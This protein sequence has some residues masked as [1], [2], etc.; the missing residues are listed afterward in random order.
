[1]RRLPLIGLPFLALTA[2]CSQSGDTTAD[3]DTAMPAAE[4]ST[5]SDPAMSD[6]TSTTPTNDSATGS[7]ATPQDPN[8]TGPDTTPPAPG[9][10]STGQT[11]M[12]QTKGEPGTPPDSGPSGQDKG[13]TPPPGR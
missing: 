12:G 1:M 9:Q 13:T 5:M 7:M 2:A 6:P 11:S 3:G 10:S 8:Q 4:N